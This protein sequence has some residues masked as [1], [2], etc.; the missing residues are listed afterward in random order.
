MTNIRN[1]A[2]MIFKV[3]KNS[4]K[5]HIERRIE[6]VIDVYLPP[7]LPALL[8]EHPLHTRAA[9]KQLNNWLLK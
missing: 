7:L 6:D 2:K 8:L 3:G 1:I 4:Y 9:S 5:A